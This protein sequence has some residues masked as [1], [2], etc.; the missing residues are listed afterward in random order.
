MAALRARLVVKKTTLGK[1]TV[2]QVVNTTDYSPRET[3]TKARIDGLIRGGVE[4][5]IK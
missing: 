3:L 4:V 5:T 2:V 1:Y